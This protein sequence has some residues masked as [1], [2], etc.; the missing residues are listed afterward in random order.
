MALKQFFTFQRML[1]PLLVQLLFWLGLLAIL[2]TAVSDFIAHEVWQGILV[3]LL[4]PVLVRLCC[5]LLVV[6][7]RIN[8]TLTDINNHLRKRASQD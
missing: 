3:L 8:E 6:I 4:G 5:E 2:L 1:M 7:F